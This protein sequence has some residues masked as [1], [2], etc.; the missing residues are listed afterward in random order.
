MKCKICKRKFIPTI[1][2]DKQMTCLSAS[3]II[4]WGK[5]RE[6]I[7]WKAEKKEIKKSLKTNNDYFKHALK[8]FN[9]YIRARDINKPCISCL[10]HPGEYKIT[11]GHFYPQ[12]DYRM[13][14]FNEDNAH[15]QCWY[16]C[17]KKKHGNLH[18]YRRNLIKRIGIARVHA[19]DQ[20]S[21]D[22]ISMSIEELIKVKDIFK[23]KRNMQNEITKLDP[24]E[25]EKK[26]IEYLEKAEANAK[27]EALIY[28]EKIKSKNQAFEKKLEN[29]R[30]LI[31]KAGEL[32]EKGRE[33]LKADQKALK[34]L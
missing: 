27:K 5:K 23:K 13:L 28:Q 7:N 18:E 20:K 21:T 32:G 14:A 8:Y 29:A 25:F 24:K 10:S 30:E 26:A 19:L 34:E 11:S 15:G 4:E 2:L 9:S 33:K 22:P 17:N 3:C 1:N 31:K 16:N 6:L 12:G